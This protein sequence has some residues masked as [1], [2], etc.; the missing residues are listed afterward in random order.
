MNFIK[1]PGI[2]NHN[3]GAPRDWNSERN[4]SCGTL[5]VKVEKFGDTVRF[6]SHWRPS[7][8]DLRVLNAG[9]FVELAIY[10]GMHPPVSL[11]VLAAQPA[12]EAPTWLAS[13]ETLPG[14]GG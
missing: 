11:D 5:P 2:H 4:G 6:K 14:A 13:D 1:L 9:G 12:A 7:E 10:G 8:D 3:F